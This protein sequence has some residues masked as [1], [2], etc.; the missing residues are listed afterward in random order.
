M[1]QINPA[2]A[3]PVDKELENIKKLRKQKEEQDKNA[4]KKLFAV[5]KLS[6]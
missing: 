4:L 1:K 5:E 2:M 3:A 6:I